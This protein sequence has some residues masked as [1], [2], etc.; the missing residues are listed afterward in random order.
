MHSLLGSK[1]KWV[2]INIEV[3]NYSGSQG[4]KKVPWQGGS[5]SGNEANDTEARRGDGQ[6]HSRVSR[7]G[8]SKRRF[9]RA[10]ARNGV[11]RQS[12]RSNT[13]DENKDCDGAAGILSTDMKLL[14]D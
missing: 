9:V 2:P 8:V 13:E 6:G 14:M 1:P 4:R 7:G 5:R 12:Q 11:R 3:K 10:G